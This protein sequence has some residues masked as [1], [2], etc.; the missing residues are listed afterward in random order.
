MSIIY[1]SFYQFLPKFKK[2]GTMYVRTFEKIDFSNDTMGNG[3]IPYRTVPYRKWKIFSES[4]ENISRY[5]F[6]VES[7][8]TLRLRYRKMSV[9]FKKIVFQKMNIFDKKGCEWNYG[10]VP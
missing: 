10:T 4:F 6:I 7:F 1:L 8:R 3:T 2:T 5:F 9:F